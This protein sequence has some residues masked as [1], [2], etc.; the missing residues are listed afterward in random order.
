[1]EPEKTKSK[2]SSKK[3]KFIG[4]KECGRTDKTLIKAT[5]SYYC[6]DC[7]NSLHKRRFD[8]HKKNI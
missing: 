8:K 1:M 2:N 5:D 6:T 3:L 4:C 7:F